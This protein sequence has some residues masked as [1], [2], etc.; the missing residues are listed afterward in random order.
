MGLNGIIKRYDSNEVKT[1]SNNVLV[2]KNEVPNM[3][4]KFQ[5]IL[6]MDVKSVNLIILRLY[7][8]NKTGYDKIR[9]FYILFEYLSYVFTK[10]FR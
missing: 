10:Y 4:D 6:H 8:C 5:S 7:E 9:K 1:L 3:K 2:L